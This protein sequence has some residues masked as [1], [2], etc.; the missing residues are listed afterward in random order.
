MAR[1]YRYYAKYWYDTP[2]GWRIYDRN[3]TY[4]AGDTMPIAQCWTRDAAFKIR[5]LLNNEEEA[6]RVEA[7]KK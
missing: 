6:K 2:R 4:D 5:D 1:Y 7:Q 3:L